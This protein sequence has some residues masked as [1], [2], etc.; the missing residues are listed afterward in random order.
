VHDYTFILNPMAGKG[1][2]RRADELLEALLRGS[3]MKFKAWHTEAAGH[4]T[5]LA[6]QATTSHVVAVGGDGT[7]N[8][9]VNGLA[10]TDKILGIIPTGSGN[11][12]IKS[13]GIPH[14]MKKALQVLQNGRVRPID[15][16]R[17][18][19]GRS[20]NGSIAYAPARLFANGVG[21]G[22]DAAVARRVSEITGLRGTALYLLAVLQ[23]LGRYRAPEFVVRADAEV[24]SRRQLLIAVGNGRCA[25][26]GFYLTPDAKVDDGFLDVA[27]IEDI[28]IV[29]ALRLIPGVM[30][31]KPVTNT[32]VTYRRIKRLEVSSS[33]EFDVHADGEIVGREVHGVR[34]EIVPGVL[35]V[36]GG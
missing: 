34:L 36:V 13:V 9:V 17:V 24:W 23:T 11:D 18:Q 8:E 14:A 27:V 5:Q 29:K 33:Q 28:P 35:K 21:I 19:T 32:S 6:R 3:G 7:I 31:G 25:G 20:S 2:G 26:G 15:V 30:G 10:G 22:F 16:G 4:A 1:S 12:F